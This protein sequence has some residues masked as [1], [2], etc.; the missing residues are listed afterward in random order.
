MQITNIFL[1]LILSTAVA[2]KGNSTKSTSTK[3]LCNEMENLQSLMKLASNTTKLDAETKN[4]ETKIATIQA[5][6]SAAA[7]TLST[8]ESNTTLVSTCATMSACS[9]MEDL[10]ETIALAANTTKLDKKFK[11]NATKIADFQAKA[12]TAQTKLDTMTSNTTLVS[13]CSDLAA[14]KESK[15]ASDSN[16]ASASA[17]ASAT[18]ASSSSKSTSSSTSGAFLNARVGGVLSAAVVVAM[19][20]LLL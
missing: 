12:A 2:A 19:G 7:S 9:K 10:Q 6:A 16:S 13:D 18:T 1:T 8:M 5:K 17:S 3:A 4:N 20:I 11:N 15:K 14:E